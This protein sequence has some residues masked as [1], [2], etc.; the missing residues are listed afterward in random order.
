MRSTPDFRWPGLIAYRIE[1]PYRSLVSDGTDIKSDMNSLVAIV[2][3][4]HKPDGS[5]GHM[6]IMS[7]RHSNGTQRLPSEEEETPPTTED[8][9]FLAWPANPRSTLDVCVA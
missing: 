2:V 5:L 4:S 3:R 6:R 8:L 9:E 1:L 7:I